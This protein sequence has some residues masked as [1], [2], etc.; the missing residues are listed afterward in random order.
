MRMLQNIGHRLTNTHTH[1]YIYTNIAFLITYSYGLSSSS[2]I[3]INLF[4]FRQL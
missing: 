1:N 3:K 4:F 2:V